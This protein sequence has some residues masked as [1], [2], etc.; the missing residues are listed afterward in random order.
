MANK[1]KTEGQLDLG[2]SDTLALPKAASDPGAPAE[3]DMYYNT[4]SF[5]IRLYKNGSWQNLVTSPTSPNIPL[6]EIFVLSPTDISNKYVTL[7][8]TPANLDKTLL[9]VIGGPMQSYGDDFEVSGN[10]L[11]WNM[12]FLDGVL[13]AGDILVVPH[14]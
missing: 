2:N 10:Q 12:L 14:D 1:L 4:A 5:T 9:T 7:A 8:N 3:G 11:T 13:E 6:V